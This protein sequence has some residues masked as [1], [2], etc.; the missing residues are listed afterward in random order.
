MRPHSPDIFGRGARM[1]VHLDPGAGGFLVQVFS[2]RAS[3]YFF[4]LESLCNGRGRA[5]VCQRVPLRHRRRG[6]AAAARGPGFAV[7]GLHG[8]GG[9]KSLRLDARRR[10]GTEAGG[11]AG[12][13][14]G[15]AKGVVE[16]ERKK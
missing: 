1:Q 4:Y 15:A 3:F 11:R 14:G 5:G 16:C 2:S 6:V 7:S 8:R 10:G 9:P 12:G 13:R